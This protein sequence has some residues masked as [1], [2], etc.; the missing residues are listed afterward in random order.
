LSKTYKD[1]LKPEEKLQARLVA[2]LTDHSE[3]RNKLWAHYPGEGNRTNYEKYLWT[4]MGCKKNMPDLIFF[5]P[6]G[7]YTGLVLEIKTSNP[8]KKDGSSKFPDQEKMLKEFEKR[9]YLATFGWEYEKM[10][11]VILEYFGI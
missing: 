6:N 4:V 11:K 10:K 9:G 5:E 2:W 7:E 1:F 8:Y 3:L